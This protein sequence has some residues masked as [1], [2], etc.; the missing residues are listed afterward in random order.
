MAIPYFNGHIRQMPVIRLRDRASGN[1]V[2]FVNVHN[3]AD[4]RRFGDQARWRNAAVTREIALV[5][6]LSAGGAPVVM[7]GDLNDRRGAFCRLS[8]TAGLSSSDGGT[9]APCRPA[10][11]AGIDWILG[12]SSIQ[13]S[14]HT[15]DRGP[16]V[17]ATTDHPVLLTQARVAP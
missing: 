9:G 3:P 8:T 10:A 15:R 11:R 4:T 2:T 13:F 1:D 6:S 12:S 14:D 17:R 5:R 16:L 7:T